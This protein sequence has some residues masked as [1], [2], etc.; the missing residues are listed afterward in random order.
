MIWEDRAVADPLTEA[1][2]LDAALEL[3]SASARRYL[4]RIRDERVLSR[5]IEATVG[6][7]SDPMPEDGTAGNTIHAGKVALRPAIVNWLTQTE[8]VDLL[9]DVTRELTSAIRPS[10]AGR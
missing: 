4:R 7:W 6:R 2:Q 5:D 9:V 1:D 10:A 3:A 8:D